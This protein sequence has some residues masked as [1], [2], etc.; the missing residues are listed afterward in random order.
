MGIRVLSD[1][2]VGCKVCVS[3]CPFGAITVVER[4]AVIGDACTLCGSCVPSCKFQAIELTRSE[5]VNTDLAS[6]QGVWVF[7]EQREGR[8]AEVVLELLGEGRKLA[9]TLGQ[10]LVAVLL[11]HDVAGGGGGGSGTGGGFIGP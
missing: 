10:E 2:C 8:L 9:D 4:K 5:K 1:K 3:A 7:A 6:Y 11:G